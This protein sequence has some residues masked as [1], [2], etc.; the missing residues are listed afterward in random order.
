MD[1]LVIEDGSESVLLGSVNPGA[2]A[3]N[4]R[5]NRRAELLVTERQG[6]VKEGYTLEGWAEYIGDPSSAEV[7]AAR[8]MAPA[9]PVSG[10]FRLHVQR[11]RVATPLANDTGR[12]LPGGRPRREPPFRPIDFDVPG[13]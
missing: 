6:D 8:A 13:E 1:L 3:D 4:V 10:V 11:V 9:R 2:T 12:F 5:K 7:R